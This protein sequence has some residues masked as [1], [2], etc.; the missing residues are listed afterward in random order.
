MQFKCWDLDRN[1]R[2]S[3]GYLIKLF[4]S[5]AENM[6][7]NVLP[8]C[9]LVYVQCNVCHMLMYCFQLVADKILGYKDLVVL[10][11]TD[12]N[13][14]LDGKV[15]TYFELVYFVTALVPSLT[16]CLAS[17]PGNRRRTAVCISLLVMVER[18]L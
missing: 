18:L 14:L 9:K 13:Q 11:R 15:P 3:S 8:M 5:Q 16:A 2:I 4:Q 10:K 12:F 1:I 7:V 6:A 17:S